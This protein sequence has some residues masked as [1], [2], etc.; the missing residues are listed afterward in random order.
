MLSAILLVRHKWS[1][2]EY[3]RGKTNNANI[4]SPS[5]DYSYTIFMYEYSRY[6]YVIHT[7]TLNKPHQLCLVH[8]SVWKRMLYSG[9]GAYD[10]MRENRFP[11]GLETI[12]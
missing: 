11:W 10:G 5:N 2:K 6:F 7:I 1:V 12:C 9:A 3:M 8:N 4:I